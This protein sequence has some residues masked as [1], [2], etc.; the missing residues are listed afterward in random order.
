MFGSERMLDTLNSDPE[1][2]PETVLANI[3]NATDAFI[4]GAKQFDD[5]TMLC[6]EYKGKKS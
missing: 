4:K 3:R 2:P 1:A 6:F 5:L